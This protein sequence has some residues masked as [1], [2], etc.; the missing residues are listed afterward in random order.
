MRPF[1]RIQSA[2]EPLYQQDAIE[3]GGSRVVRNLLSRTSIA[4]FIHSHRC[5]YALYDIILSIS[6]RF[7]L[8]PMFVIIYF[9][10]DETPENF[11]HANLV[12]GHRYRTD[13]VCYYRF[14]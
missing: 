1:P 3:N 6:F 5:R 11:Y 2:V 4:F 12:A 8:G 10:V 7:I 14:C 13:I 9:V